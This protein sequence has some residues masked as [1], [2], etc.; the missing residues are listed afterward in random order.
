[1]FYLIIIDL[2]SFLYVF[3][4]MGYFGNSLLHIIQLLPILPL[5]WWFS[6]FK[7]SISCFAVGEFLEYPFI[8]THSFINSFIEVSLRYFFNPFI[9]SFDY[10]DSFF[11]WV[12]YY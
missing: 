5:H 11:I 1:M 9:I 2:L 8:L 4:D 7:D 12:K 10:N 3:I 6:F